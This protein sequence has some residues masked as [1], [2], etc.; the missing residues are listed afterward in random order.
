[1]EDSPNQEMQ[2]ENEG[3]IEELIRDAEVA[4]EPG[5]MAREKVVFAGDEDAPVPMVLSNLES[6]GYAIIYEITTGQSSVAN[7]N[8]LP[9]LL[10]VKNDDGTLRF[11]TRKPPYEPK[12]GTFKCMLH[13]SNP[14]RAHYDEIGLPVC[15]KANII[16]QYQVDQHMKKRHSQ[17]WAAIERERLD[18]EKQ[19]ERDFQRSLVLGRQPQVEGQS[20]LA[21]PICHE[22]FDNDQSLIHHIGVHKIKKSK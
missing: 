17:S 9:A 3:L 2:A 22:A 11:T 16:N 12:R 7:K 1:M 15:P 6:A 20:G 21:C 10:R 8:M 19:E 13:V 5:A 4:E 14:N 18:R